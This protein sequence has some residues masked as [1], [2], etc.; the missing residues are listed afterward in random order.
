ML[1]TTLTEG[2]DP[3]LHSDQGC[4]YQMKQYSY[5]LKQQGISQSMSSKGNCLDNAV[6]ETFFGL[7]KSELYIYKNLRVWFTSSVSLNC[8]SNTTITN[9]LKG[10]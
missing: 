8:I 9:V 5:A 1:D 10:N 6:I 7:L 3:V 4:H 2:D